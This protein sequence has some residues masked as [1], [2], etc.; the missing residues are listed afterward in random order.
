MKTEEQVVENANKLAMKFYN[1][2][3]YELA[4]KS[5]TLYRFDMSE[6]LKKRGMWELA[7]IAYDFIEGTDIE[8]A[9][10]NITEIQELK[11]ARWIPWMV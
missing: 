5:E 8:N 11:A 1:H 7:K 3:G 2:F 6:N 10:A 9:V 4:D